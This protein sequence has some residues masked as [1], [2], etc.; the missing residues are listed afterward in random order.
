MAPGP[1]HRR[2]DGC[3]GVCALPSHQLWEKAPPAVEKS[4]SLAPWPLR[5]RG[6]GMDCR[7]EATLRRIPNGESAVDSV[8]LVNK[9]AHPLR[10]CRFKWPAIARE[11]SSR[12]ERKFTTGSVWSGSISCWIESPA[13]IHRPAAGWHW[14]T[15]ET[16]ACRFSRPTLT[17]WGCSWRTE[18]ACS[19]AP[20]AQ[21]APS[22]CLQSAVRPGRA[23]AAVAAGGAKRGRQA[24]GTK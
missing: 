10:P 11:Y 20:G 9:R 24:K 3:A 23:P 18:S 5:R 13:T 6:G 8:G 12:G 15:S 22:V 17:R 2:Q 7:I 19:P 21:H 4:L 14:Q 1:Q 16:V